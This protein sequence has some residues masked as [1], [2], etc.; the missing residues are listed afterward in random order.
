MA[1]G[2]LSGAE[3]ARIRREGH[4]AF[5]RRTNRLLTWL[6]IAALGAFSYL[7]AS[8]V[9]GVTSGQAPQPAAPSTSPTPGQGNLSN[10]NLSHNQFFN[11][12]SPS[13]GTSSGF[14]VGST[15]GS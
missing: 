5:A 3:R 6:S 9:T 13:F 7:A 14:P 10:G 1:D 11:T 15:G 8:H 4:L 12:P 2:P